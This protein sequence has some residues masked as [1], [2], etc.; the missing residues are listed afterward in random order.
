[1]WRFSLGLL[2]HY[3][4]AGSI[5]LSGTYWYLSL[6]GRTILDLSESEFPAGEPI[7]IISIKLIGHTNV[8]VPKGTTVEIG[9]LRLLG[10]SIQEVES[11][12]ETPPYRVRVNAFTILGGVHVHS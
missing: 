10:R 4:L 8:Q 1:M 3:Q 7:R 2:G 5:R 12:D 11:I 6:M 9:G